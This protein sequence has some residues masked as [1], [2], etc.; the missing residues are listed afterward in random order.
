MHSF[1]ACSNKKELN[2]NTQDIWGMVSAEDP[3][4]MFIL[5]EKD[6]PAIDCRIY[7]KGCLY[8]HTARSRGLVYLLIRFETELDAKVAARKINGFYYVN[9]AFDDVKGEPVL[10]DFIKKV[11]LTPGAKPG[12]H[13]PPPAAAPA[14]H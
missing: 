12:N 1:S 6:Y 4:S 11:F 7:G 8:G 9:W 2:Y 13:A 10:E 3:E 14:A 5:P